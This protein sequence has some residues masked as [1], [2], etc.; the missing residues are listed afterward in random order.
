MEEPTLKSFVE[1]AF[2]DKSEE[3]GEEPEQLGFRMPA[4]WERHQEHWLGGRRMTG[5]AGGNLR[6]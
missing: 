6:R 3:G 4:E 5:L 2:V 1:A